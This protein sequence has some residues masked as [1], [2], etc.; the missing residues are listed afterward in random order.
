M[1]DLLAVSSLPTEE[2]DVLWSIKEAIGAKEVQVRLIGKTI[3]LE[4][5][6]EDVK[7]KERARAVAEALWPEVRDFIEVWEPAGADPNG[8]AIAREVGQ[9]IDRPEIEVREVAAPSFWRD[10][11]R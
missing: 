3:F 6:V 4:G 11:P 10:G 9:V 1:V 8:A 2:E 5:L 7:T